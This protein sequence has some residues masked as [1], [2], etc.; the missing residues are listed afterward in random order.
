MF[1]FKILQDS[2]SEAIYL[3]VFI[4]IFLSITFITIKR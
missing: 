3:L 4:L 2:E 1:Y